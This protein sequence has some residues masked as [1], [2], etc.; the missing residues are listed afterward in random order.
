MGT[1]GILKAPLFSTR[2]KK[3]LLWPFSFDNCFGVVKN[4]KFWFF[5][6][7]LCS[8]LFIFVVSSV[9][10]LFF[11]WF[12]QGVCLF[13]F[14]FCFFLVLFL[15]FF[16]V[17]FVFWKMCVWESV[18]EWV[19]NWVNW[20]CAGVVRFIWHSSWLIILLFSHFLCF[21]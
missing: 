20:L 21:F 3:L 7:I 14:W 8:F 12:G 4:Q 5:L 10:R 1:L 13:S 17:V 19:R 9:S 15:P 18:C 11:V 2:Q 6:F 16:G